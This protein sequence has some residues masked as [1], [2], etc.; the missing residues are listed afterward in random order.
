MSELTAVTGS[1]QWLPP[2]DSIS[3]A[4]TKLA[5]GDRKRALLFAS[6]VLISGAS[7]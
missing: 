6:G 5:V 3:H 1:N 7:S 2:K 4:D